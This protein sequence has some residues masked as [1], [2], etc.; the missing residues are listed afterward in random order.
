MAD[1]LTV[2][3][4]ESGGIKTLPEQLQRFL[5]KRIDEAYKKGADK[6]EKALSPHLADPVEIEKLRQRA[7]Q[8][9]EL[10]IGVLERDKRYEEAL[11]LRD[12]KNAELI[13]AEQ[14]K[15]SAAVKRV[16]ESVAKSIRAAAATSGARA[17]S[18]DELERLLGAEVDLDD[19][20]TEFVKD[21]DGKPR[22]DDKGQRVT[23]EGLVADYLKTHAHHVAVAPAKGGKAP[24]GTTFAGRPPVAGDARS[25]ARAKVAEN[26]TEANIG[27]LL[28]A[29]TSRT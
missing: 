8:A 23:I 5:D 18:L 7:K 1:T 26:P 27:A 20:L 11:S 13:A 25:D 3:L 10:E 21:A 9:D 14:A 17:E 6:T 4:D 28:K 19:T 29:A 22:V 12:K 24:G 16:R 2:E 15:T